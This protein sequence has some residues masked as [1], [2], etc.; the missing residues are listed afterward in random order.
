MTLHVPSDRVALSNMPVAE[1]IRTSS[2]VKTIKFQ[3]SPRMS[4]YLVAIVVGEL[5]Y[6]EGHTKDGETELQFTIE[7]FCLSV[8]IKRQCL[9]I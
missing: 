5:E 6:V 7:D 1:E 9:L 2:K 8:L 4:T 3:E